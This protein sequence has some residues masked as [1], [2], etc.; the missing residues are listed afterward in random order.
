MDD[1]ENNTTSMLGREKQLKNQNKAIGR[2]IACQNAPKVVESEGEGGQ[3]CCKGGTKL[4]VYSQLGAD[5]FGE[6]SLCCEACSR[7]QSAA[8]DAP[9]A[10][11]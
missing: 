7:E 10:A 1:D 5:D 4:A 11:L 9:G 8:S 3:L 2:V 6:G